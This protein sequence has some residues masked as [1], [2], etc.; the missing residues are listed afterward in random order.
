[1]KQILIFAVIICL[2]VIF[3]ACSDDSNPVQSA[4]PRVF[5]PSALWDTASGRVASS[6][7]SLAARDTFLF[8]G[9]ADSG[10]FVSTNNGLSWTKHFNGLLNVN[11][12]LVRDTNLLAGT[13]VGVNISADNGLSWDPAS[14]ITSQVYSFTRK[15]TNLFA[16]TSSGV[17][18]STDDGSSWG[19]TPL[20]GSVRAIVVKDTNLFAGTSAGVYKSTDDGSSWNA[21]NNGLPAV[22][23]YAL[24]VKDTN[25]FAATTSGVYRSSNDSSWTLVNDGLNSAIYS[26]ARPTSFFV[27]G[28]G[29]LAGFNVYQGIYL[30]VTNGASWFS[31][32]AGLPNFTAN[33]FVY[34]GS[35]VF[36]GGINLAAG[37]G[38][39]RHAL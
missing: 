15:D 5:D 2:I 34:N 29:V 35:Y 33:A 12:L 7:L 28:S 10:V 39:W 20:T 8:A 6:V 11:A 1:M 13:S 4:A 21:I 18:I 14:G 32:N 24:A 26:G 37:G 17:Y 9:T 22:I 30:T 27:Y 3:W 36:V 25:L 31:C 23:I 16:G 19:T 38:V